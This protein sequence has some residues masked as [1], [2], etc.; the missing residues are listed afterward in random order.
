KGIWYAQYRGTPNEAQPALN[1][2]ALKNGEWLEDYSDITSVVRGGGIAW[3]KDYTMLAIPKGNNLLGI[4]SVEKGENGIALNQLHSLSLSSIRG[5]NDI[6]WDYANNIYACDNGKEVLQQIQLPAEE[7]TA[8]TPTNFT[9]E[10]VATAVKDLNTKVNNS[11][12]KYIE[13]GMIVI[14]KDGVKY[15]VA[16]QTI[17]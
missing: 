2:V 17:K 8:V 16:G 3:N 14:E 11:V 15:N 6:A 13:N 10:V 12:R 4:Y 5:F 7:P 9:F 1:H